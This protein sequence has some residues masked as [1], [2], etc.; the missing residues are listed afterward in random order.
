[1]SKKLATLALAAAFSAA[2]AVPAV[3]A[4]GRD[5]HYRGHHHHGHHHRGRGYWKDGKWIALGIIGAAIGAAIAESEDRECYYRRGRR[6]C[7]Y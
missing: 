6:Y 7:R 3:E 2:T 5:R 4:G 1:M